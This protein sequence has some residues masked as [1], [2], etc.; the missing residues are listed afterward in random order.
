M[1]LVKSFSLFI[2]IN[3]SC[4]KAGPIPEANAKE[5]D[6][7]TI[8]KTKNGRE[9]VITNKKVEKIINSLAKTSVFLWP[10]LSAKYPLEISNTN[11][12]R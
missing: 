4:I 12:A 6:K 9:S 7:N 2:C 1:T 8:P 11:D 10:N 5:V 3:V